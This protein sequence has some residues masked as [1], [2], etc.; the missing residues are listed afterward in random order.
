MHNPFVGFSFQM[1]QTTK[2]CDSGVGGAAKS[3]LIVVYHRDF[4]SHGYPPL[5][6]RVEPCFNH[7]KETGIL[8][9]ENVQIVEPQ[10]V[11]DE[12]LY[13]V[14]TKRHVADVKASGYF[15]VAA[16][17]AGGVVTAA[18]MIVGGAADN[19]FCFVGA[20]GHHA[21]REGYWGFCF[22][23]DICIAI[24]H[25]RT[26][27]FSEK[28]AIIDIDPHYGDG[29]RDIIGEDPSILHINFHSGSPRG[30]R[31]SDEMNNLDICL[32]FDATD[33]VFISYARMAVDEAH[34]FSPGI[35]FVVFG[36]DSHESDYGAFRL[37][38]EAYPRFAQAVGLR[39]P[40]GVCYVLSGGSGVENGKRAIAG[41]LSYLS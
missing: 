1:T 40:R 37:S 41:V 26:G 39:F 7:I 19:A 33:E 15:E 20:A 28:V 24:K 10:P 13:L 38:D 31:H 2:K 29:T 25:L 27:G 30:E 6:D 11:L 14:H 17:S 5:K 4:A 22:L 8:S 32:P 23:N 12:L 16:R 34:K 18:Q 9:R 3:K 36:Y 35:V 21:S